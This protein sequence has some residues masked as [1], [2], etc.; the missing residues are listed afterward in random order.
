VLLR[1]RVAVLLGHTEVDD[2]NH[3]SG[4]SAWPSDEEVVGFDVSVDEVLFVDRLDAGKLSDISGKTL[5]MHVS[6]IS[7]HLLGHHD[8]C[9][10]GKPAVA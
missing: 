6:T 8:D 1:L 4:F 5:L 10:Y 9:L 3:I 7:Y 2:V